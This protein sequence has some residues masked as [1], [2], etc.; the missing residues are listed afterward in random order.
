[1]ISIDKAR[2]KELAIFEKEISKARDS[3]Y[4]I[5]ISHLFID[6]LLDRYIL[7]STV[8]D[9]GFTG[10]HGLSFAQKV[11]LVSAMSDINPQLVDS[12]NKLNEIR[13]DCAH[14]FGHEI[15]LEKIEKLGRTL[16][17]DYKRILEVYPGIETDVVA[18]ISWNICGQMVHATLWQEGHR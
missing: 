1:M 7:A 3:V 5:L 18:P 6:H 11:K 4:G 13:N 8:K 16:G 12:L 2:D 10:K 15:S 14:E 17:K 9:V